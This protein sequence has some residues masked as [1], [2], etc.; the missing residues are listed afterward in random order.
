MHRRCFDSPLG[1]VA[2]SGKLARH[3]STSQHRFQGPGCWQKPLGAP[4][5]N[6]LLSDAASSRATGYRR[7]QQLP[8]TVQ[9]RHPIL[10]HRRPLR[11]VASTLVTSRSTLLRRRIAR[12]L[13][14]RRLLVVPCSAGIIHARLL[15]KEKRAGGDCNSR[16]HMQ[17][18]KRAPDLRCRAPNSSLKNL[19]RVYSRGRSTSGTWGCSTRV[20][21]GPGAG[22]AAPACICACTSGSMESKSM[23][24]LQ[25][26]QRRLPA[27][28][29]PPS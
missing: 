12:L 13:W 27:R 2:T 19:M 26:L 11:R 1:V 4:R 14:Q 8:V 22:R 6:G 3:A 24:A 23:A 5:R 28:S 16:T 18:R 7:S 15:Q 20:R 29:G 25:P 21:R 10:R 17:K 9:Q